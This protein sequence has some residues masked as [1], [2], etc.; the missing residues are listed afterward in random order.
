MDFWKPSAGPSGPAYIQ[1]ALLFHLP[2]TAFGGQCA[3]GWCRGELSRGGRGDVLHPQ[4]RLV[5]LD[6]SRWLAAHRGCRKGCGVE[7]TCWPVRRRA[8]E[9]TVSA[10]FGR[11][12]LEALK[13]PRLGGKEPSDDDYRV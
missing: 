10:P 11:V 2:A 1:L 8:D 7:R 13:R 12:D 3:S 9:I 5:Q 4:N 6:N